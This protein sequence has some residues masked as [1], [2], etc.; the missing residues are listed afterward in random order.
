M[1]YDDDGLINQAGDLILSRNTQ[2]GLITGS[3]LGNITDTWSYNGFGEPTDY[4]VSYNGTPIYQI[5]YVRDK[6][7]RIIEKTETVEGE[8]DTYGYT[9]DLAGR[10]TEVT[11][12]DTTIASYTYDSNGNRLTYTDS[13]GTINGSSDDQDRLMQYGKT[14]YKYT[15][16]GELLEK[17]SG[18]LKSTYK[19]DVMGNLAAV[20]LPNLKK[21]TYL[22]DGRNRRIGKKV[23][24]TL[25]QG[26]L[27]QDDLKPI[28][29]LDGSNG[30]VSRFVYARRDNVPN[31]M[32]KGGVTY[33]IITDHL[34]SP[35]LV[36]DVATDTVA[37]RMDY[38][39]FGQ[40]LSDT[41]PGFQ[42]FG[43]AGGLYDRDTK[44]VRFGARDYEAETGRWTAKDPAGFGGKDTNV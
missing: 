31:Y 40:V 26:F 23:N 44:L 11:K 22:I 28:V 21:I 36:I 18:G 5:Q 3:T 8:T 25:V 6:L 34:G 39:E 9:Y 10:L 13:G 30:I 1:Q 35:R 7:G 17:T 43:F 16:N 41:S 27:Y 32:I 20:N 19:Y 4:N 42:P 33:R 37:Q 12:N 14:K 38:D 29:E 24:G 15:V 2:N